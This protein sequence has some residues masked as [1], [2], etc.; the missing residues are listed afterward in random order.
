MKKSN[1]YLLLFVFGFLLNACTYDFIAEAPAET[2]VP[3]DSTV[4]ISFSTQI[5]PIFTNKCVSCHETGGQS[6]DLTAANAYKSLTSMNLVNTATPASSLIY[7]YPNPTNTSV[8]T[9][10]KFSTSEAQLVLTW[11]QQGAKNN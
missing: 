7:N 11:I 8:H 1:I 3:V 2:V 6:P 9:W 10:K 5:A 4:A